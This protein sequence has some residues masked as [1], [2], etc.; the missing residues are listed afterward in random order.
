MPLPGTRVIHPALQAHLAPVAEGGMTAT[1]DLYDPDDKPT[2]AYDRATGRTTRPVQQPAFAG[3]PARVQPLS[4]GQGEAVGDAA[5]QDVIT[6]PYLVAIPHQLLADESWTVVV[7]GN[8]DDP[9]M[10]GRRLTVRRV[11]YA[12]Q[13][14]QRD[15]FCDDE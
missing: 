11:S 2:P 5:G 12:T 1:V 15:L 3:V 7:R 6:P 9:A 13:R 10:V 14:L 8:P 4:R